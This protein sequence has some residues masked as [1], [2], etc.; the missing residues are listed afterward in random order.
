MMN[1]I[2]LKPNVQPVQQSPRP[3]PVH[4]K[5]S[6][7][8]ELDNLVQQG[9]IRK[10]TQYTDWVNAIVLVKRKNNTIRVCLDPRPL[11]DLMRSKNTSGYFSFYIDNISIKT[12]ST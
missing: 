4:L 12:Y 1:T 3:V 6:Y 11:K 7:N 10:V 2:Q 9:V 8:S 5:D